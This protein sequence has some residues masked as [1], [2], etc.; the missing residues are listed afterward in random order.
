VRR[1]VA[2]HFVKGRE[3]CVVAAIADPLRP[4]IFDLPM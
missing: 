4:L 2:G 3:H 1:V